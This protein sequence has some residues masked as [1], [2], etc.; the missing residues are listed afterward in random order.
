MLKMVMTIALVVAF[1]LGWTATT[2]SS[3]MSQNRDIRVIVDGVPVVFRDVHPQMVNS[4]VLVPV[5]GVFEALGYEVEWFPASRTARLEAPWQ[6]YTEIHSIEIQMDSTTFTSLRVGEAPRV[7]RPDVPQQLINGRAM[8]PLSAITQTMVGVIVRWDGEN[9]TVIITTEGGGAPVPTPTPPANTPAPT[10]VPTTSPTPAP[11]ATPVPTPMPS[12]DGFVDVNGI[13]PRNYTDSQWLES[14]D[15]TMSAIQLPNRRLTEAEQ[16]TWR[17]EYQSLG[18]MNAFEMEIVRLVNEIRVYHRLTQLH[19][20]TVFSEAARFY[21]Q[22][23]VNLELPLSHNGGPYGGNGG[24]PRAW[25]YR[26]PGA[27]NAARG[28]TPQSVV[29]SWMNSSGHRAAILW[30]EAVYI[31]VGSFS[32]T[33]YMPMGMWDAINGD[34]NVIW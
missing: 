24:A 19:I 4:R 13:G 10:A 5:R 21:A 33:V 11:I 8:L 12:V 18:G 9:R 31:G 28:A 7:I 17:N 14:R 15:S 3:A 29:N 26:G 27:G 23:L 2:L 22:T 32:S 30:A 25:G 6:H 20:D 1:S 16:N 34:P